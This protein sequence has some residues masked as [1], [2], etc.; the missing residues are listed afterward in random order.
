MKQSSMGA[1]LYQ[2][3]QNGCFQSDGHRKNYPRVRI[4]M[5]FSFVINS[6]QSADAELVNVL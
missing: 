4:D 5:L 1:R 6:H 3:S 2:T